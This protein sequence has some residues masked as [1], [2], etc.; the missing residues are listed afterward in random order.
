[1]GFLIHPSVA[2]TLPANPCVADVA[3]GTAIFLRN[4][5]THYPGAALD[6]FDISSELFPS[7]APPGVDLNIFDV[8]TPVPDELRGKYDLVHVRLLAAAMGPDDWT[9]AVQNVSQLLK[10]GGWLQ[11]EECDFAGVKHFRA[12]VDSQVGTARRLG[13]AFRDALIERFKHG[14]STLP[15]DMRVSGLSPV[16]SDF[17]SS[18]RVPETRE[19]MTANGMKAI[20]SWMKIMAAKGAFAGEDLAALEREAHEDIKSGCYVRYDIHV[21]CGQMPHVG[22]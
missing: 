2:T 21:A 4:F 10:P 5:R 17:A 13:F 16:L 14:W 12:R 7:P 8:K 20:L 3:T 19:P 6:G 1:M 22:Q 9:P 18:D 11:W 15:N